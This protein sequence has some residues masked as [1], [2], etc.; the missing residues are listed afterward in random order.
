MQVP[1]R[2]GEGASHRGQVPGWTPTLWP[3]CLP[4]VRPHQFSLEGLVHPEPH[5]SAPT[6]SLPSLLLPTPQGRPAPTSLWS[7]PLV[8]TSE[9][10]VDSA[11][12][13]PSTRTVQPLRFTQDR[14]SESAVPGGSFLARG[15]MMEHLQGTAG[16][17]SPGEHGELQVGASGGSHH[18]ALRGPVDRPGRGV[19]QASA[20]RRR[21][22]A[23]APPPET[24]PPRQAPTPPLTP[25]VPLL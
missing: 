6:A 16:P 11:P 25:C 18:G 1:D 23:H 9:P 15:G 13:N 17:R 12:C 21:A 20:C 10:N 19:G 7:L 2:V 4:W 24:P 22:V 3:C 5:P 8:L 14:L